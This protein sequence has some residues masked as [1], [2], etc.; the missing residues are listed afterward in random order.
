MVTEE[1]VIYRWLVE[2]DMHLADIVACRE[3]QLLQYQKGRICSGSM[4]VYFIIL[5]RYGG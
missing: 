5:E 3:R 4:A 1:M 2:K